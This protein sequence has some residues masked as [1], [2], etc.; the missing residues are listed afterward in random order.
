M[1]LLVT[2]ATGQLAQKLGAGTT[3]ENPV[4]AVGRP[5]LDICRPETITAA[6]ADL[7]PDVIVNAAAYT[8]VDKAES[9]PE[10]ASA[11]NRDGA[12]N[13]AA[14]AAAAGLPVIHVSTDYV[15]SGEKDEPYVE[16]D[17]AGPL[18]VYGRSKLAGEEA[19]ARAN[20]RHIIL[21]TSWVYSDTGNNFVR[22]MLRLAT[23]REELGIVADQFGNP[24]FAGDLAHGVIHIARHL[25]EDREFAGYGVYHLSGSGKTSWAGFARH[26]FEVSGRLGGPVARVR[27]ITTAEFPTPARRPLNSCL[28]TGKYS[29][30]FGWSP[31]EWRISLAV[32][33]NRLVGVS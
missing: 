3:P 2:G 15:F 13:V 31:P 23:E 20:S 12:G 10:I 16:T 7:R 24:T 1:R 14:A 9:E 8:A 27:D 33:L 32:V 18:G 5:D 29:S 11:I 28:A 4:L 22:T 19:V 21:R 26:I 30:R 6:I 17:S 25:V